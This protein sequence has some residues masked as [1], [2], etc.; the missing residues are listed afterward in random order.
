MR[1]MVSQSPSPSQPTRP[2]A[3]SATDLLAGILQEEQRQ[4]ATLGKIH[5]NLTIIGIM[6]MIVFC[7][8]LLWSLFSYIGYRDARAR[9]EAELSQAQENAEAAQREMLRSIEALNANQ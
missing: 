2:S 9:A 6:A 8:L 5:T 7:V 4:T 3:P 1:K